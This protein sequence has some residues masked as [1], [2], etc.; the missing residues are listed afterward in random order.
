MKPVLYILTA[1]CLLLT[2]CGSNLDLSGK[3]ARTPCLYLQPDSLKLSYACNGSGISE[4][5]VYENTGPKQ[6]YGRLLYRQSW[7]VPIRS[8]IL[9]ISKDSI[10]G[11]YIQLDLNLD[12][13]GAREHYEIGLAPGDLDK[14]QK[15]IARYFGH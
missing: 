4:L 8:F 7:S 14:K 3:G 11:R 6:Y 5:K 12:G 10:A 9:P 13:S 2:G 1:L 15:L